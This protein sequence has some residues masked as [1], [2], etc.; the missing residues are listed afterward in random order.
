M[1]LYEITLFVLVV[2]LSCQVINLKSHAAAVEINFQCVFDS[3]V[4]SKHQPAPSEGS[5][6]AKMTLNIKNRSGFFCFQIL[7][8][9][10]VEFTMIFK[11]EW[12]N[13]ITNDATVGQSGAVMRLSADI[14][15]VFF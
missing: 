15:A 13:R 12:K 4:L 7:S 11:K 3:F 6:S 2:L 8:E 10:V 5:L 1:I 14:L 9:G